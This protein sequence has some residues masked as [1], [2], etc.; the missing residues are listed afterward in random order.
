MAS[1]NVHTN[2]E[3]ECIDHAWDGNRFWVMLRSGAVWEGDRSINYNTR[4]CDRSFAVRDA[5]LHSQQTPGIDFYIMCV[6]GVV[7]VPTTPP[8]SHYRALNK[9]P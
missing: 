5:E 3:H 7:R 6:T 1:P 9:R 4:Y 8:P 2:P